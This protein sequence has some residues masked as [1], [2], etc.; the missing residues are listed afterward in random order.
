MSLAPEDRQ[1]S[2]LG[3]ANGRRLGLPD[4]I[5]NAMLQAASAS[6]HHVS[7]LN[8]TNSGAESAGKRRKCD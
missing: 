3:S 6:S 1:V 5:S 7:K 8:A 2:V 4:L